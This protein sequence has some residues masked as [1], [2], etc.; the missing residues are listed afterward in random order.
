MTAGDGC[1]VVAAGATAGAAFAAGNCGVDYRLTSQIVMRPTMSGSSR[2]RNRL[3]P[4]KM[5]QN[6]ETGGSG[7]N[8]FESV[9]A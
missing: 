9:T 2:D 6:N 5:S 4:P 8:V 1:I 7:G 3:A